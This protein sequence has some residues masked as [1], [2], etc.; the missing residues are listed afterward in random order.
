VCLTAPAYY[1]VRA[2]IAA[3]F[4][5]VRWAPDVG[6]AQRAE[7]EA[8]FGLAHGTLLEPPTWSYQL[9]NTDPSNV[10]ALVKHRSV[11]DTHKINRATFDVEGATSP[12]R[13]LRSAL[14]LGFGISAAAWVGFALRHAVARRARAGLPSAIAWLKRHATVDRSSPSRIEPVARWET[15]VGLALGLLFLGPLLVYGPFDVEES[16]LGFFSSQ[17]FYRNLFAGRWP[18]WL[19][20]LGFGTPMPIGQRFDFHP[21]FALGTL[22]S[23]RAAV[24]AV[25]VV[26]VIVMT[27]YF[28]RFAAVLGIGPLVR[29]GL[30][31]CYLFS[32]PSMNYF[33]STDWLS[34]AVGWSLYP[35]LAYYVH[36][37][38]LEED[39]PKIGIPAVRLACLGAFWF[40]NS[41][42]GYLAPL[43][44][45]LG[46]YAVLIAPPRARVYGCLLAAAGLCAAASA[47]RLYFLLSE[48]RFF[49]LSLPRYTQAG[50]TLFDYAFAAVVPFTRLSDGGRQPFIG[51]VIGTAALASVFRR[52]HTRGAHPAGLVFLATAGL[53][54]LPLSLFAPLKLFSAVWFFRDPM[55]LFG[56][57]AGGV[58][59]QR[60]VDAR[61]ARGPMM[62]VAIMSAQLLQQSAAIRPAFSLVPTLAGPLHFYRDQQTPVGLGRVI[63]DRARTYGPRLY[64]PEDVRRML[65]GALADFGIHSITD[66]S[67]W[68]LDPINGW[69]KNVATDRIHPSWQYMHG[70]IFGQ[71]DVVAN[72]SLL[73]VLGINLVLATPADGPFAP[74]LVFRDRQPTGS[75]NA[76]V[77]EERDLVLLGNPHAWPRA[78]LLREGAGRERLPLRPACE[79][80]AALCRDFSALEQQRLP[81][82]VRLHEDDGRYIASFPPSSQ[83]RLLFISAMYRPEWQA[84]SARRAL[85][86]EPAA[87]A[88]LGVIVPAGVEEVEIRFN[89]RTRVVLAWIAYGTMLT[90]L[91]VLGASTWRRRGRALTG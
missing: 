21:A 61:P 49:P 8:R 9:E 79:H 78:V 32:L 11:A 7:L 13:I 86:V 68:G 76:Y 10:S 40:L 70:M 3:P 64:T 51:I 6:D 27:V 34:V 57:L 47:E 38:V 65:R 25:W 90:L 20:D 22:I 77:P 37:T 53:T 46:L 4:V 55:V 52:A 67:L 75:G 18:F 24:S 54:L 16:G 45:A 19:N 84:S 56:L 88:F 59:L 17:I 31:A 71:R 36:R 30:T 5:N 12:W 63:A 23:L 43:V 85:P 15:V 29:T 74:G 39:G 72:Q 80:H 83:A 33:Q 14:S 26:H 89:P 82:R 48:A 1:F 35:V 50:Y 91:A 41:H 62:A 81:D 44:L 28:R 66:L 60:G 69:F 2:Q 42:P 73:N 87:D 58:V